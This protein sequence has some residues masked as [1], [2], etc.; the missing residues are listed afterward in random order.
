MKN[1]KDISIDI[2]NII[3]LL[4]NFNFSYN[5]P[6]FGLTLTLSVQN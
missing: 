4:I 5:E 2:Y 1:N 6:N 3:N